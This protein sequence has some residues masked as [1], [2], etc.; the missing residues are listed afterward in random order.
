MIFMA[1]NR[2]N[3]NQGDAMKNPLSYIKTMCAAVK[4]TANDTA[5]SIKTGADF[6]RYAYSK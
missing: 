1:Y 3:H 4:K 2:K 5:I 6:L